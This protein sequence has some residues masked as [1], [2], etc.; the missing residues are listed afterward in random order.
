MWCCRRTDSVSGRSISTASWSSLSVTGA[1]YRIS[2]SI[3]ELEQPKEIASCKSGIPSSSRAWFKI[4]NSVALCFRLI[5]FSC[6][7]LKKVRFLSDWDMKTYDHTHPKFDIP[8]RMQQL[9][10]DL[11][12]R[13]YIEKDDVFRNTTSKTSKG[14]SY[15]RNEEAQPSSKDIRYSAIERLERCASDKIRCS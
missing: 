7:S 13:G 1:P 8:H 5:L 15:S 4:G 6:W 12:E 11:Y 2:S 14:K 9:W 3:I 10:I